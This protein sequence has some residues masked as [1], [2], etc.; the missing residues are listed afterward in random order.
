MK[1]EA[2]AMNMAVPSMFMLQP[3]GRTNLVILGSTFTFSSINVKVTGRA[4][5]VDAVAN[6]VRVPKQLVRENWI[7]KQI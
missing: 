7:K 3:M 1:I 5:A 2:I 4:A 6:A